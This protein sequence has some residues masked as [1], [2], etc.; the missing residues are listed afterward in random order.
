MPDPQTIELLG[1]NRLVE[2]LL[3]AGL[4]VALPF[5][6][7][8]IDLIAYEDTGEGVAAFS[9]RPIQMKVASD[10]RFNLDRKYQV[11][12]GLIIAFV[13]NLGDPDKTVTY[14]LTYADVL[15]IADQMGY[16]QTSWRENGRYACTSISGK[17]RA[18]LEAH[19]MTPAKWRMLI[20]GRIPHSDREIDGGARCATS[21]R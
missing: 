15:A 9:A 21:G 6:D 16:T 12:P 11:F 10:E 7:R 20:T 3:R 5:R 2:E 1:R 8:G 14:A 17:L 13:W 18:L 19:R 4:E